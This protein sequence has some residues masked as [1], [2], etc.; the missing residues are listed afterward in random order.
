MTLQR[1]PCEPE[2]PTRFLSRNLEK[3]TRVPQFTKLADAIPRNERLLHREN[4]GGFVMCEITK[5]PGR[6][7]QD[8]LNS[9]ILAF[10]RGCDRCHARARDF[11]RAYRRA[12][13]IAKWRWE[14]KC[15]RQLASGISVQ[16]I[17]AQKSDW[18]DHNCA[19]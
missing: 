9:V 2:S 19:E 8:A 1:P 3:T 6:T 10:W 12:P 17:A 15:R 18:T 5:R 11:S 4:R 16:K 13:Q 7:L 14:R